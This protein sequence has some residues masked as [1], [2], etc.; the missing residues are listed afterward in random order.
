MCFYCEKKSHNANVFQVRIKVLDFSLPC[1]TFP[2]LSPGQGAGAT[3]GKKTGQPRV[4]GN[5]LVGEMSINQIIT[6][7]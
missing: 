4:R 2:A 5:I 3:T 1:S 7:V 6:D